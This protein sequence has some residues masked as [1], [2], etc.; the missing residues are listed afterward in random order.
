M[1]ILTMIMTHKEALPT[2]RRHLP[3]WEN[4]PGKIFFTSPVDSMMMEKIGKHPELAIGFAEHHGELSAQRI[5]EIFKFALEYYEEWDHL[6]LMEYDAFALDITV[7]VIPP[8]GGV[9]ATKYLQNKPIKFKGKFYLHYP[10]LFTRIA[11]EKVYKYLPEIKRNDR[12]F[13]DRFIGRAVELARIPV[14]DLMKEKKAYTKNTILH[15]HHSQ[16]REAVK[17]G[18]I[19]FHGVKDEETLKVICPNLYT[20]WTNDTNGFS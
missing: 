19:F 6:L 16:L 18:A 3:I 2:V 14:R 15:K 9:S 4:C 17:N 10:M 8:P 11:T 7:D 13:S 5:I 12:H 20:V 1:K